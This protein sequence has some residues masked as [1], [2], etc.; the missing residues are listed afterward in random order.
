[1]PNFEI[2]NFKFGLDTR[3][4]QLTSQ[5]GTL[6]T[7]K[8]AYI[9]EGGEIVKR[10]R[11]TDLDT[12]ISLDTLGQTAMFPGVFI[13]S[14][15]YVFGSA[16]AIG[17]SVTQSQPVIVSAV[18]QTYFTGVYQQLKHPT[19]TNDTAISYDN[20]KH[21]MTELV[22]AD[23]YNGKTLVVASYADGNQFLF[24]DGTI[25]QQSANGMVM[26]GRTTVA[27]LADDL[28]RQF[29]P[30]G[31][32]V[33]A[34]VDENAAAQNGSS[35]VK[36]PV[37]DYFGGI[38]SV[39]SDGGVFGIRQFDNTSAPVAGVKASAKFSITVNT[40]TFEVL[41]PA[42]AETTTP[43]VSLTGTTI[44]ANA[45]G[46]AS[47][48]IDIATAINDFT[49]DH[50]YTA[51]N[52]GINV[53]V[54]APLGYD[55]SVALDLTVNVTTG[56]VAGGSTTG[57]ALTATITTPVP[58]GTNASGRVSFADGVLTVERFVNV[59]TGTH[60]VRAG[61][62]M[63]VAG[64]SPSYS[65]Q[66]NETEVGSANGITPNSSTTQSLRPALEMEPNTIVSG[67]FKCVVTDNT[68]GT[69]L[70]VTRFITV[71]LICTY[72]QGL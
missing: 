51:V 63:T 38:L 27:D 41:A 15:F 49:S 43:T 34:N 25:V 16:L 28:D 47:T 11:F 61:L 19:L 65:Y 58:I 53:E 37:S 26:A 18:P 52:D 57:T 40:G 39:D 67:S 69:P 30:I 17:S 36:S 8:N 6:V 45:G 4:E 22:F 64:G 9:N 21:R 71:Q 55:I 50:G 31:W 12:Y 7:L 14:T 20:T 2:P 70:T 66:W 35:M 59:P 10:G 72:V 60:L 44:A 62:R 1:M 32:E 33:D 24:Y 5:I 13:E 48:A 56:T 23:V 68:A 54:F 3:K 42:Q 29:E 46:A